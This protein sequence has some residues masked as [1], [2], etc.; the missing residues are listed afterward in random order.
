VSITSLASEQKITSPVT[1]SRLHNVKSFRGIDTGSR[2]T[3]IFARLGGL[4]RMGGKSA[5]GAFVAV[6]LYAL[7]EKIGAIT[8]VNAGEKIDEIQKL[9]AKTISNQME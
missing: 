5:L 3:Q 2:T 8:S 6:G 1:K 4:R 7:A 9:R